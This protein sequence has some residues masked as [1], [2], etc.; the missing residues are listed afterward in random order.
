[1]EKNLIYGLR[2]PRNDM[3]YYIGKTTVGEERPITHLH[4]SH[5]EKVRSW[6]EELKSFRMEP[7]IDILE[8][9][10][11]IMELNKKERYWINVFEKINSNLFNKLSI[12]KKNIFSLSDLKWE[13][14]DDVIEIISDIPLLIKCIR[15]KYN[16]NQEELSKLCG[17]TR[18]TISI[19]ENTKDSKITVSLLLKIINVGEKINDLSI[20]K[21]RVRINRLRNK[22]RKEDIML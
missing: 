16:I 12:D 8:N 4:Y 5:N 20:N 9:N 14:L 3:Y 7:I 18:S 17:V 13:K 21:K 19:A 10:I 6:V 11:D 2:D 1:M 22:N 15:L